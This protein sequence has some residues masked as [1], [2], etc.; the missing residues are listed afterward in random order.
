MCACVCAWHTVDKPSALKAQAWW[1]FLCIRMIDI[2]CLTKDIITHICTSHKCPY[3]RAL[4]V[5]HIRS[6]L[7][8]IAAKS[9][10]KKKKYI[11]S[12]LQR[13]KYWPSLNGLLKI[14]FCLFNTLDNKWGREKVEASL[15][16]CLFGF[17]N[18]CISVVLY[19][20][21]VYVHICFQNMW[22]THFCVS[23]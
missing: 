10:G 16:A 4:S 13:S 3:A 1:Y 2:E 17:Y 22:C 21:R 15:C 5:S 9:P 8:I 14:A 11:Y 19:A 23:N 18:K 7:W 6:S 20:I 12:S